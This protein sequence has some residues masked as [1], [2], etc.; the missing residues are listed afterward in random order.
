MLFNICTPKEYGSSVSS[1]SQLVLLLMMVLL[2]PNEWDGRSTLR[3]SH[4]IFF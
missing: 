4:C 1:A 3:F 2:V